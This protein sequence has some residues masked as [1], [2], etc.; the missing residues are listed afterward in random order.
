MK[1]L[2]V[3]FQGLSLDK[4]NDK[5]QKGKEMEEL[6]QSMQKTLA[7]V[8]ALYLKMH[9]FHW[10]V[11]GRD[12]YEYHTFLQTLYEEVYES[13][14]DIA[15]HIRALDGYAPGALGVYAQMSEVKDNTE[16]GPARTMMAELL[17]DNQRAINALTMSY[18]LADRDKQIGLANFLQDRIDKHQKHGWMIKAST[19]E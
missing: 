7:T 3:N 2:G 17:L 19:K 15:E 18:V 12:F 1:A 9:Q 16:A 5:Y 4:I 11:Q 8:F 13:V 10:N 6:I 14:D